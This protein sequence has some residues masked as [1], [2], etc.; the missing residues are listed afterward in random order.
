M[1]FTIILLFLLVNNLCFAQSMQD[2]Y[3][4]WN[5]DRARDSTQAYI[6][7]FSD[8]VKKNPDSLGIVTPLVMRGLNAS[9]CDEDGNLLMYTN[10]CTVADKNHQVMPNGR[11]L[12]NNDYFQMLGDSCFRGYVGRQ[13]ILILPDPG[14]E[15]GYYVLHKPI[16]FNP[17]QNIFYLELRY[18]YVDMELNNGDGAV[19][20]KNIVISEDNEIFSSYLTG[21]NHSNGKD[22]WILNPISGSNG[23][24]TYHL[25]ENGFTEKRV[26]N[27]GPDFDIDASASGTAVFSPDGNSYAYYNKGDNLLLYDF[28]RTTG[29]LSDLRQL[30]LKTNAP[31]ATFISSIEFSPNSRFLYAAIE[32]SLWQIDTYE[33]DLIEGTELIDVWDGTQD[34]FATTFTLMAL[35]PNCKIYMC[36]GSSTNTYHVINQPN[37]KGIACDFVQRGIQLPFT[38]SLANMPNFPR[39]RVDED[40]KCDPTITSIFG[41]HVYYR[42]DMNVYPNPVR[43]V[44]K[45]EVP[46][47]K[48]GR[49]VVFDMQGQLVWSDHEIDIYRDKVQLDLSGLVVGTYSV[50]FVPDDNRERLVFTAQVVK[51][52]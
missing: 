33:S 21:I 28:D 1:K 27:I 15:N 26:Q 52:E 43:D 20:D 2:Y 46:E 30:T 47:G 22:W 31:P 23:Y 38:S 17:Q 44:L 25:D 8:K 48:K 42:R 36:S 14:Y 9:V 34:P 5:N 10:G 7:D 49:I 51:V 18:S 39:F 16:I 11:N 50:E 35:A 45:V 24:L 41:D 40:D 19:T 12:N 3:W 29:D 6:F 32:D 37:E 13:D 4:I